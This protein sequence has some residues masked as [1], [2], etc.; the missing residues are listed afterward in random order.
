[1]APVEARG[2]GVDVVHCAGVTGRVRRRAVLD[3]LDLTLAPGE[4]AGLTGPG[5]SGKTLLLS[6]LTGLATP[7][8][9]TITVLGRPV[10]D[11][12]TA[13][14]VGA[15]VGRPGFAPWRTGRQHLAAV[16]AAG[17]PP[18]PGA[19]DEALELTG[20]ARQAGR[21]LRHWTGPQRHRLALAT[22]LLGRPRLLL[23]DEPVAGLDPD[24]A[25]H[26]TRVLGRLAADGVPMLLT[27]RRLGRLEPLCTRLL[28][29]RDGRAVPAERTGVRLRGRALDA[30]VVLEPAPE[31]APEGEDA[32]AAAR[33]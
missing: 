20:L 10:P 25:A 32:G 19:I 24:G 28:T 26:L 7:A 2:A 4:V 33:G 15:L 5:G 29:L 30:A 3:H 17:P 22:A 13:A 18:A 6:L 12:A 9:G 23:L 1:M 21:R 31:R 16:A 8:A 27:G 11:P 14:Q